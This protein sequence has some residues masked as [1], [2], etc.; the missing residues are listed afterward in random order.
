MVKIDIVHGDKYTLWTLLK[1]RRVWAA[2]LSAI[3]TALSVLGLAQW[4]PV[5]TMVAGVLC[6]S[7]YVVPKQ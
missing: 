5:V 6:L 1:Q 2:G 7:S 3:A 4:I